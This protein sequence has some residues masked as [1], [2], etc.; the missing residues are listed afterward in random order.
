[1]SWSRKFWFLSCLCFVPAS[2]L[3]IYF[4]S[5]WVLPLLG[6]FLLLVLPHAKPCEGFCKSITLFCIS[7]SFIVTAFSYSLVLFFSAVALF[8]SSNDLH[9]CTFSTPCVEYEFLYTFY[10]FDLPL[11]SLFCCSN[12]SPIILS[13]KH[14]P[15]IQVGISITWISFPWEKTPIEISSIPTRLRVWLRGCLLRLLSALT[16]NCA[17]S[18]QSIGWL[19]YVID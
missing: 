2:S 6:W 12:F 10:D 9:L 13:S 18:F 5:D 3:S 16:P 14:L 8:S 11:S 7:H 15:L 4:P 17:S 1:M 19:K